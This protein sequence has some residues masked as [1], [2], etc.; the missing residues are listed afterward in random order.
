MLTLKGHR[1]IWIIFILD[2][3]ADH[4][5][6]GYMADGDVQIKIEITAIWTM[7]KC[8]SCADKDVILGVILVAQIAFWRVA[9]VY[10]VQSYLIQSRLA[11]S[12]FCNTWPKLLLGHIWQP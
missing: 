7:P 1:I 5:S 4:G 11:V 6:E 10:I 3:D 2:K 9:H 12:T 8:K